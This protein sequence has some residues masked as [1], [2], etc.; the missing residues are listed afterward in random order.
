MGFDRNRVL[1]YYILFDK[2]QE[3]TA[4]YLFDHPVDE[5]ENQ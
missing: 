5:D 4:N 2:D 1:H 3:M